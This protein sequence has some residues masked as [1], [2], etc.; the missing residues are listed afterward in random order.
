MNYLYYKRNIIWKTKWTPV[1]K[2]TLQSYIAVPCA[3]SVLSAFHHTPQGKRQIVVII[4][5]GHQISHNCARLQLYVVHADSLRGTRL[6]SKHS[7]LA[8]LIELL[9][10]RKSTDQII[11]QPHLDVSVDFRRFKWTR[12]SVNGVIWLIKRYI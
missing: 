7:I 3:S 9:S 10:P 11:I 8:L 1:L 4:E 12:P 2:A 6:V 5:H